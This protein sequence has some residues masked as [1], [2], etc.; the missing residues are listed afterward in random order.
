VC[1]L[2]PYS[3]P[4][5]TQEGTGCGLHRRRGALIKNYNFEWIAL[6]VA[7]PLK[8]SAKSVWKVRAKDLETRYQYKFTGGGVFS[9]PNS[10]MFW[11]DNISVMFGDTNL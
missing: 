1:R 6:P 8:V 4:L 2:R 5:Q 10:L 3:F 7:D 9:F 11:H